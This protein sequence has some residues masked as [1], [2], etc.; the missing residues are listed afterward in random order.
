M[1]VFGGLRGGGGGGIFWKGLKVVKGLRVVRRFVNAAFRITFRSKLSMETLEA[2]N[3]G[4]KEAARKRM[5][6]LHSQDAGAALQLRAHGGH[7]LVVITS[8]FCCTVA[9]GGG[10]SFNHSKIEWLSFS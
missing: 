7:V 6:A 5:E 4:G 9:G 10:E 2:V 1:C 3:L 8:Y